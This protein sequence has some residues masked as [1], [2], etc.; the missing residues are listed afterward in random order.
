MGWTRVILCVVETAG[1]SVP[2]AP[3]SNI[4]ST[5]SL[6]KTVR[7]PEY[8]EPSLLLAVMRVSWFRVY[9]IRRGPT[10]DR[11]RLRR[12]HSKEA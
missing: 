7:L 5:N 8:R 6:L 10:F 4:R 9:E 3:A 1:L 2:S 12:G 11:E